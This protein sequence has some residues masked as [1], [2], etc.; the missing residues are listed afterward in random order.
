MKYL[1]VRLLKTDILGIYCTLNI[2]FKDLNNYVYNFLFCA[3]RTSF[4]FS[5]AMWHNLVSFLIEKTINVVRD[6]KFATPK[7][8]FITYVNIF[9][10]SLNIKRIS[11]V[12]SDLI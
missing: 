9:H 1:L 8:S 3:V 5:V 11:K 10:G 6:I 12:I 4:L 2:L 7:T